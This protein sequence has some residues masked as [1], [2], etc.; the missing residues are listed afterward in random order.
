MAFR[1]TR[2]ASHIRWVLLW[3]N[4]PFSVRQLWAQAPPTHFLFETVRSGGPGGPRGSPQRRWRNRDLA[5]LPGFQTPAGGPFAG[6]GLLAEGRWSPALS[7]LG[8]RTTWRPLQRPAVDTSALP[9]PAR[10]DTGLGERPGGPGTGL[11]PPLAPLGGRGHVP[12]RLSVGAT[13][14]LAGWAVGTVQEE[15]R[16]ARINTKAKCRFPKSEIN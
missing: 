8:Q 12:L 2:V 4:C 6:G 5:S 10:C 1:Q 14:T 16:P 13:G 11:A 3:K 7:G 15:S 9:G